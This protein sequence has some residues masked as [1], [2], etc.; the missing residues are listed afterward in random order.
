MNV[1]AKEVL[2]RELELANRKFCMSGDKK[3]LDR[4]KELAK[5]LQDIRDIG[6]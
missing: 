2:I 3:D 6:Q 5:Q 4:A 1:Y